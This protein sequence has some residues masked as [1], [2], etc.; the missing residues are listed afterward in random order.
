MGAATLIGYSIEL[1]A[2]KTNTRTYFRKIATEDSP[3][4]LGMKLRRDN[5][6]GGRHRIV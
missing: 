5:Q 4:G 3:P 1:S 2:L 6:P